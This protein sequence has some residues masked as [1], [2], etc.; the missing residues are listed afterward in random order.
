MTDTEKDGLSANKPAPQLAAVLYQI[1]SR[2]WADE[3]VAFIARNREAIV[4]SDAHPTE[5][6]TGLWR[7][8]VG[9]E[10]YAMTRVGLMMTV[11]RAVSEL[12]AMPEVRKEKNR[13]EMLRLADSQRR[14]REFTERAAVEEERQR[15]EREERKRLKAEEAE[16]RKV[17]GPAVLLTN[18]EATFVRL[19]PE[20]R[21]AARWRCFK[22]LAR[23]RERYL[24]LG[25]EFEE[26][27]D[28]ARRLH[29]ERLA[30]AKRMTTLQVLADHQGVAR[31]RIRHHLARQERRLKYAS[32]G[33]VPLHASEF[34][35]LTEV[36]L[37]A[38]AELAAHV[39]LE[40]R[41]EVGGVD[42]RA[43]L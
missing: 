29:D 32:F 7:K 10:G 34:G 37:K 15:L 13:R 42:E 38:V 16:R 27:H 3:V 5:I 24:A 6:A 30:A 19:A 12:V 33:N 18:A 35:P 23:V 2:D 25:F 21:K 36:E 40:L 8:E 11:I 39:K 9:L 4:A 20:A 14:Y 26:A 22:Q 17:E 31:E 1:E 41:N 28:A 43:K